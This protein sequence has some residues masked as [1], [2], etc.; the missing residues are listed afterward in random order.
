M[1]SKSRLSHAELVAARTRQDWD[2][3]WEQ[4]IPLAKLAVRRL[5]EEGLLDPY[6]S[7]EDLM[8]DAMLA[9][10]MA[11]RKWQ[12]EKGAFS[13]WVMVR[14]RGA[15]LDSITAAATGMVGGRRSGVTVVSMHGEGHT[16]YA[17]NEEEDAEFALE[18]PVVPEGLGDPAE[19]ASNLQTHSHVEALIGSL[20]EKDAD[21]LKRIYGLG[22]P[23]ET[24]AQY[25]ARERLALR[26]VKY[27]LANAL[28]Y[29]A[30]VK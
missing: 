9:A 29:F 5:M 1:N 11:V 28:S 16:S 20:P 19:E 17:E 2:L 10:G 4:A 26:T 7:R 22:F 25:A 24:I 18:Y 12:P 14:V 30:P 3:L 21:M 27:R 15:A 13:T 8:Q 23:K 6:H